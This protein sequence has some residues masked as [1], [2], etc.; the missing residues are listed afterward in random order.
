MTRIKA[1]IEYD[2]TYYHGFQRQPGM[3]TI[4]STLVE[5][6]Q[7]VTGEKLELWAAGRTDAR[8]HARGQVIAFD[9][10]SS[11]PPGRFARALNAVLPE[12]IKVLQSEEAAFGFHPRYDARLKHYSYLV[13]RQ[14]AGRVFYRHQAYYLPYALDLGA[15]QE[16]AARL[17]GTHDFTSFCASGSGARN[18]IRTVVSC[19]VLERPPFLQINVVGDGFL[20]NMVRII[21]GTLLKVGQKKMVP[22]QIDEVILG[23]NR[24]LAGPTVPPQGLYLMA[25]IY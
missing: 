5:A 13:Y 1:T 20:Y 24:A 10:N 9:T 22:D 6:I 3:T 19:R 11:I 2:G 23:R 4:E 18:K 8:V 7:K 25:V 15:M 14:E 16:A 12:D 17:Q 21:V